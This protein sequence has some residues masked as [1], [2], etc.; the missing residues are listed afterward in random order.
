ME[1]RRVTVIG[2]GTMGRQIALNAAINGFDTTVNDS[3]PSVL[4]KVEAW[5]KQ[6]LEGRVAKGKMTAE[7]AAAVAGRFHME[8]GLEKAAAQ[9]DL[10][11]EAVIEDLEVKKELFTKL[12]QIC[13]AETIL[14]SNSSTFFPSQYNVATKR[15]HKVIGA[16]YFNPALVMQLVEVVLS[17]QTDEDTIQTLQ[18]F[19]AA[20]KK[21]VIV[22][23]KEI[24]GF[25][26]N[27]LFGG[28]CSA[29]W[30]LLEGGYA[31]VED[32]DIAAEKGLGH[33]MGPFRTMDAS[34]LDT[35]YSVRK[36]RHE[37]DPVKHPAPSPIL[38]QKVRKG[39]T[40]VK[41]GKGFYDYTK[42]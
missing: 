26:V 13:P 16:H 9:A 38:E 15:P 2:G 34:G 20:I 35:I 32:I 29:A 42:K 21:Q 4:E 39:E 6:Y 8:S 1:I 24:E 31:T 11:I 22:V 19:G 33:P 3:F 30:E 36:S 5:S 25:V 37:L 14:A 17:E 12:D 7:E 41:A 28:I 27:N 40:G 10:V 23:R 18:A